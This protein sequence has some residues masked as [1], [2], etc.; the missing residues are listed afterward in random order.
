VPIAASTVGV[1]S[2]ATLGRLAYFTIKP[3]G[4]PITALAWSPDGTTLAVGG[5]GGVV[6]LW[7]LE[8]GPL[9]ERSFVGLAPLP[10]VGEAIQELAF[11]PNGLLLAAS[12]KSHTTTIGHMLA[13]P[14]ATMAT[15]QVSTG[16]LVGEPADLGAGNS[17]NGSDVVAFSHDSKLL[18]ATMLA[19]GI[20]VFDASSGRVVRTLADPGDDGISLAFAPRGTLLAEG[21]V[22]GTVEMWDALTGKRLA[23][24]LLAD[25]ASITDLV[26]DPSGRRFATTSYED[27][28]IKLW[29]TSGLQQEGPRLVSD[30][31][32]T[33]AV[34]FLP[35]GNLLAVDD[36]GN[37]FTW[38]ASLDAWEQRA[39]SLA[40][41]NLTRAEWAE[42]VGGPSYTSVCP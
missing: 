28:T 8:G 3:S 39:C 15:W 36:R 18:A 27:G 21:T 13:S 25:T 34:A 4:D 26:F 12:D 10:G 32:A 20:R 6:Q 23:E 41:R 35:G 24:P 1:F 7:N 14:L 40:G 16:V 22:G 2:T 17:V 9:V 29:F 30:P 31:G 42:L 38:P 19:G 11:S 37:A 5:H 33:S